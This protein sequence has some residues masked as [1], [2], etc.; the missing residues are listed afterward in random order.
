[1][2][3][4]LSRS[5]AFLLIMACLIAPA[6]LFADVI[7]FRPKAEADDA[8]QALQVLGNFTRLT[9]GMIKIIASTGEEWVVPESAIISIR[10]TR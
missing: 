10:H 3:R 4:M 9:S 7:T 1:M 8:G 6:G 5:F 2:S